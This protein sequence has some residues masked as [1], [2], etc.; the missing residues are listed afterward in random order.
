[1][2]RFNHGFVMKRPSI[3]GLGLMGRPF[4]QDCVFP[5]NLACVPSA[6]MG[7]WHGIVSASLSLCMMMSLVQSL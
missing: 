1:M 3:L 6:M 5:W 2:I 4:D 7:F